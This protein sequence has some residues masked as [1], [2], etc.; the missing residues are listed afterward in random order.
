MVSDTDKDRSKCLTTLEQIETRLSGSTEPMAY[1]DRLLLLDSQHC[2][3][4]LL[5]E[6]FRLRVESAHL[7]AQMNSMRGR[8]DE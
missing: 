8:S 1:S 6:S 4:S 5:A 7:K 2:I 3:K